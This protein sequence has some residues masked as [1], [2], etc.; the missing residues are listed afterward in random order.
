MCGGISV[1][2][3]PLQY[4]SGF[5]LILYYFYYHSF[6]TYFETGSMMLQ[7]HKKLLPH[8]YSSCSVAKPCPTLWPHGL[9]HDRPPCP[10]P[11][12]G[13]CSNSCP[14]SW[15]CHP[16]ISSSVTHF[17]SHPQSFPA[18]GSFPMSSHQVAKVLELQFQYHFSQW[19][20]RIDFLRIDWFDLLAAQGPLKSLL[21]HCSFKALI[22]CH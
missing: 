11:S 13:A 4:M 21:Q 14:L 3:I 17:S 5:I 6:V 22:L 15:W 18:S 1:S 9:Q 16:T 20:F 10:S 2:S 8:Y 12:P 7:N 19:I